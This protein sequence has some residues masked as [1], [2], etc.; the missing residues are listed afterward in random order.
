MEHSGAQLC[1][2]TSVESIRLRAKSQT[3]KSSIQYTLST[4]SGTEQTAFDN[5]VIATPW[6]F[7][8]ISTGAG[9]IT[10]RIDEV[11]Y[12]KLYVTLFTSPYMLRTDMYGLERG[13]KPPS[14]VYTT[15][16]K[17]ESPRY[18]DPAGHTGFLSL[19]TLRTVTN[20]ATQRR[21]FLYKMFAMDDILVEY[22]DK[23]FDADAAEEADGAEDG[24]EARPSRKVSWHYSRAFHSYP[25]ELPRVTFQDPVVGNGVYYTS[26]IE[27]FISTMETSAFMG[28]NVARL[29]ADD[30][31]GKPSGGAA[32]LW[33]QPPEAASTS[34]G[35]QRGDFFESLE[36]DLDEMFFMGEL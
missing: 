14:N 7:S 12:R 9:V 21:E 31:A 26:G 35:R 23:F 5:I 33:G 32:Q 25:I 20:P 30:L 8:N 1:R 27:S 2:N 22:L 19:S 4:S 28:K 13:S 6:Q 16:V 36:N 18:D 15:L 17:G 34:R 3:S 10:H 24:D 11:P 29:I